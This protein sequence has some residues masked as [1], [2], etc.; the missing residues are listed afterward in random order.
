M[1]V[2]KEKMTVTMKLGAAA[3]T[4]SRTEVKVRDVASVIDEPVERGGTNQG[5]SPTETLMAALLG[6]T[7]TITHK[8]AHKHGVEL[9][10]MALRLEAQFDRRGVT[11]QEEI[12]LPFPAV[13]L[14][15][16]I[17]TDAP[18]AAVEAV[19]RDLRRFCKHYKDISAR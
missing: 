6:C 16:D 17:V 18:D 7:N 11:L 4:H 9:R 1:V 12:E 13:R 8:C 19:K 3:A 14:F 5:L 2:V 10:Q 15:I